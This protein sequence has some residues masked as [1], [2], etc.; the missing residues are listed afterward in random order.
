MPNEI[1][2]ETN[3]KDSETGIGASAKQMDFM[4]FLIGAVIVVLLAGLCG[5]LIAVGIGWEVSDASK[6]ATYEDL[7]DQV[8]AQ[9]AKIDL[10]IQETTLLN[11]INTIK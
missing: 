2:T 1:P 7:K 8:T 9:N 5:C 4:Q 10:L 11:K 6:Q 3:R